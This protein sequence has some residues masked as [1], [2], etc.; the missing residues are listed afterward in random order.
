[1]FTNEGNLA[2]VKG[3]NDKRY[4][5]KL[6]SLTSNGLDEKKHLGLY[7]HVNSPKI[8]DNQYSVYNIDKEMFYRILKIKLKGIKYYVVV[9]IIKDVKCKFR[10]L[11][12][13]NLNGD[14]IKEVPVIE[15]IKAL[16][17]NRNVSDVDELCGELIYE[18]NTTN[19]M[20]VSSDIVKS[21]YE[22]LN[23]PELFSFR[24][25]GDICDTE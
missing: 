7:E 13:L 5:Y 24:K 4:I 1:M 22:V 18:I 6:Y 10:E 15:I 20:I 23:E 21:N 17:V 9:G 2:M 11:Y 16:S 3:E 8:Y 14:L 12:M 19:L 25:R